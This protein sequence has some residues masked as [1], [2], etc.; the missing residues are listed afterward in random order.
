MSDWFSSLELFSQVYWGIALLGSFIFVIT[1]ILSFVGSVGVELDIDSEI[2][3]DTG[4]GFQ[5]ITLKNLIGFFT[6]FGWSG[7]AC[8]DAGFTQ[9]LTIVISISCGL[10]M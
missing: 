8:I 1:M 5:F 10:I 4:I 3:S 9:A 2:E 6:L 7:I